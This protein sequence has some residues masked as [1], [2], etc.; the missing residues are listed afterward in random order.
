MMIA[1]AGRRIDAADAAQRRFPFQ[2]LHR[3]KEDIR[4]LF[5]ELKPQTLV[6]S[7]ANGA[8]LLAL[9]AAQDLSIDTHIVLPFAPEI[10]RNTSV[11]D[12]PG[13]WGKRFDHALKI[14]RSHENL[15]L[16][17]CPEHGPSA[18]L[19]TNAK[20]IAE[21]QDIAR[22][23]HT[24]V[25]AVVVWDGQSRGAHDITSEFRHAALRACLQIKE[26]CTL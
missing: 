4:T 21:A 3:V 17:D 15:I 19:A 10:F 6:C 7:A 1:L 24:T 16:M 12:R 13:G 8:D 22:R 14:V 25:T 5:I 26:I 2:N 20:I 23:L 18:Y 9:E 11:V